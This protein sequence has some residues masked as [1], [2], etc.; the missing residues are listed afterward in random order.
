MKQINQIQRTLV[1]L[2]TLALNIGC[3]DNFLTL[4]PQDVMEPTS[5]TAD[6][7]DG[8]QNAIYGGI[9]SSYNAFQDGFADNAYSRNSWDS[10]GK[11]IQTNT[12][13]ADTEFEDDDFGYAK[14]YSTIRRCN[15]LLEYAEKNPNISAFSRKQYIAQARTV[16]AFAYMKLNLFYGDI[17]LITT[18]INEFPKGGIAQTPSPEIRKW[19]LQ[20]F[21]QAIADLPVEKKSGYITRSVAYAMKARAAYYFGEY[22]LAKAASRWVIDNGGYTLFTTDYTATPYMV[23]DA[24]FFSKLVDF[25]ATGFSKEAFIKGIFNYENLFQTDNNSEV[26]FAKEYLA[27]ETYGDLQRVTIFMTSNM[28]G[29]YAWNT[30]APIQDIVDAYWSIDGRSK[31][32]LASIA[33]RQAA[34]KKLKD[35]VNSIQTSQN[36]DFNTAVKTIASDLPNKA[37]LQQF[38][39]R[40]SRLYASIVFPFAAINKYRMGEFQIYDHTQSNFGETG[41]VWRKWG[42]L[43][44]ITTSKG[45]YYKSGLDFPLIRLAEMLLI[46]AEAQTQLEGYDGTVAA[47]LNKIRDRCGMPPVPTG[48]S[49]EEALNFIRKER[50]LELAAEGLRYLDIRLYE[51]NTRNG[52]FKGEEAASNVMKGDIVDPV[53]VRSSKVWAERLMLLPL[54]TTALDRNPALKQNKGY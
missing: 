47:E 32:Q 6:Q 53:T 13:A 51:D 42:S 39:N 36:V 33:E 9:G 20:E 26:I 17:P 37:F 16:R 14:S 15:L 5:M 28:T 46:Y 4:K 43:K 8:L 50:R 35:E 27:T 40:D 21:D 10:Y 49:K 48:L 52:G 1:I 34:Y 11:L 44:D 23:K 29:M 19:V 38:K 12:I 25:N 41:F 18:V 2:S 3:S 30:M 22:T 45:V 54:P 24:E 7:L 31:P